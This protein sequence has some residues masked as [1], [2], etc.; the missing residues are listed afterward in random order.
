[1]YPRT[2]LKNIY[3]YTKIS[4]TQRGKIQNVWHAIKYDQ[5]CKEEVKFTNNEENDQSTKNIPELTY[6]RNDQK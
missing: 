6:V 4:N 2:M 3:R 1:M 5:I